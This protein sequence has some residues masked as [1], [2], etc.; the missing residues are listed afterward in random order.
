MNPHVGEARHIE[1]AEAVLGK[2]DLI[3]NVVPHSDREAVAEHRRR[4]EALEQLRRQVVVVLL[5]LEGVLEQADQLDAGAVHRVA[6]LDGD[7]LG[8]VPRELSKGAD[9]A[10]EGTLGAI[11]RE[12]RLP[13]NH[14]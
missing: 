11:T 7:A 13:E 3:S 2:I 4:P 9:H 14:N 1:L 6:L 8:L 10:L 5:V 12:R